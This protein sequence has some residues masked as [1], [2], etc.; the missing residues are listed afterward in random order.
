MGWPEGGPIYSASLIE[1]CEDHAITPKSLV[2]SNVHAC[3]SNRLPFVLRFVYI[4]AQ[5]T[6]IA[7]QSKPNSSQPRPL[8]ILSDFAKAMSEAKTPVET[9]V[10]MQT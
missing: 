1:V 8:T 6:H 10:F 2:S 3:A 9:K 4:N 7:V 5:S